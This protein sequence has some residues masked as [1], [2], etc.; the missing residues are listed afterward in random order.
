MCIG[1]P[2][3]ITAKDGNRGRAS[4]K[5]IE[6]DLDLSLTPEVEVGQHVLA[7]LGAA[8]EIITAQFAAEVEGAHAALEAAM[9]GGDV[10]AGFADL[11]NREPALPPHLQAA[12]AAGR[13]TA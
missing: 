8:R 9:S 3:I 6:E 1:I 2:M 5:G 4:R 10:D 7:F 11:V 12:L 13:T